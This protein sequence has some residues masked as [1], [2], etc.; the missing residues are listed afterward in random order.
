MQ[1]S[2]LSADL[3]YAELADLYDENCEPFSTVEQCDLFLRVANMLRRRTPEEADHSG[4]RIKTRDIEI[5]MQEARRKKGVLLMCA[6]PTEVIV[7]GA[8]REGD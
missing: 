3:S 6:R 8:L 1:A 5:A 7:A 4:E 2:D